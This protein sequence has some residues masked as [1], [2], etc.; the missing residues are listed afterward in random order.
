VRIAA[1]VGVVASDI[2]SI[3][4]FVASNY[5]KG[6]LGQICKCP[7]LAMATKRQVPTD[8]LPRNRKIGNLRDLTVAEVGRPIGMKSSYLQSLSGKGSASGFG[9]N[10]VV[11]PPW[12]LV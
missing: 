4:V 3:P 9:G 11:L 6:A 5:T 1:Y 8:G 2:A 12:R 7:I 10:L